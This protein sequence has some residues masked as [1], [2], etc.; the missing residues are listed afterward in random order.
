M[1]SGTGRMRPRRGMRIDKWLVF[2]PGVA[3]GAGFG[4]R[5]PGVRSFLLFFPFPFTCID[6]H[7]DAASGRGYAI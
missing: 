7:G 2:G 5:R 1:P 3:F 4:V 6:T